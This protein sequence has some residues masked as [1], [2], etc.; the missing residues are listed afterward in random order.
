MRISTF[1]SAI[2]FGVLVSG[3]AYALDA[4]APAAP[5]ADAAAKAAKSAEC[6]KQAD[7]KGLHGKERKKFREE[8]KNAK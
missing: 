5:S 6:S 2:A 3:A 1:V 4:A 8:C 7:A